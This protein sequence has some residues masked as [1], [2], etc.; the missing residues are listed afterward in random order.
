[1]DERTRELLALAD[2]AQ[3]RL[4]GALA[5]VGLDRAALPTLA[6]RLRGRLP[7]AELERVEAAR[8]ALEGGPPRRRPGSSKL[9]IPVGIRGRERRR[10]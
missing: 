5:G 3:R 10:R 4:D 6:A 8:A 7:R 2:G 9:S 1:M